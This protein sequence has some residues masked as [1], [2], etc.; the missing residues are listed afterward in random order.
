MAPA[1]LELFKFALSMIHYG[2]PDWYERHVGPLREWYRRD[3]L[4][5]IT[6][7]QT[8]DELKQELDRLRHERLTRKQSKLTNGTTGLDDELRG[9]LASIPNPVLL[10]ELNQAQAQSKMGTDTKGDFDWK[11]QDKKWV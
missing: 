11:K 3:D 6:P 7:P 5:Q 10:N 8:T 2:D 4:R 9:P 1:Q